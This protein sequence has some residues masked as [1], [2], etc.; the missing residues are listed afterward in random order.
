MRKW[1]VAFC[2]FFWIVS[3]TVSA[4]GRK[5]NES[6]E[7]GDPSGFTE[8]INIEDK[9]P[10]KWNFY[11]EAQ[12]KGGNTTLAGPHNIY[13]DPESDLPVTRIINPQTNMHVMGNLNIVGTCV[14][15]DGV[16]HVEL[17]VT[18]GS[19]GKGEVVTEARADGADFWS[20]FLDTSDTDKWRD[21]VY[22]V[23][24]WGVD[25]NGL[26]GISDK[27]P[28]KS[29][30]LDQV[31]WNLDRKKPEIKVTSHDLGALVSG[32]VTLKGT[33]WDGNGV[34]S[35]TYSLDNGV[36]YQPVNLKYDTKN[37]IY[38][39][40]LTI[41]TKTVDDGPTVLLFKAKDKMRTEGALS[42]L[43]FVNNTGPDV[44]ILYPD[45]NE[46]VNGIFTVAGMAQHK[47]GLA[48]LS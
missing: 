45:P 16:D 44:Q 22:T 28:V 21:G 2:I 34:D 8:S 33:A 9:K 38:N 4:G 20:Y 17:V 7:A 12:D 39:F 6:R 13:I 5:D 24:A 15:D 14:D 42:F 48:S 47:V 25:I 18:R 10:G 36:K 35:L 1:L 43:M 37:D 40:D 31:S 30:K 46:K 3:F 32:K 19:D 29:R 41:D 27:F 26:S 23:T 11:L